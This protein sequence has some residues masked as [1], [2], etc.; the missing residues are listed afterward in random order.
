M[1]TRLKELL[2][3][4]AIAPLAGRLP[5]SVKR[6]LVGGALRREAEEVP[7][8]AGRGLL[9]RLY[10]KGEGLE[11]GASHYPVP[12][13]RGVRVRYVDFAE[14]GELR[15]RHPELD[16]PPPDIVDD[17]AVLASV[18]DG[19]QDFLIACHV[20]EHLADPVGAF[21]N[22][23]RVL[24]PGG[25]LLLAIPDKRFTFDFHRPVTPWEHLKRDHE[26]GWTDGEHF[27]Q[28][29]RE[30]R[31]TF[32]IEDEDAV[33]SL[34]ARLRENPGTAHL[35][36]WSQTEMLEFVAALRRYGLDFEVEAFSAYGNEGAFVLRKGERR[37]E[38]LTG[39]SLREAES[40]VR[41]IL[42]SLGSRC[43]VR[44]RDR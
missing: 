32:G 30:Y 19:S 7:L 2:T 6:Y 16:I 13:P 41:E 12:V 3:V 37:D 36:V 42:D 23:L 29:E 20:I 24:K 26:E 40:Q 4:K 8:A 18:A 33:A 10:L 39:S 34:I 44:L 28:F 35:H 14:V 11:I 21:K 17:G 15:R 43:A 9:A 25:V 38:A 5:Q 27:G 22:W 1:L 31:E